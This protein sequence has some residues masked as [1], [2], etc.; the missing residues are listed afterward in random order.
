MDRMLTP[1]PLRREPRQPEPGEFWF[2]ESLTVEFV[3]LGEVTTAWRT[4]NA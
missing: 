4:A 3:V 1:E 2:G